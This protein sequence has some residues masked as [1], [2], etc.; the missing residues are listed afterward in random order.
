MS[1]V[2]KQL[3]HVMMPLI[4]FIHVLGYQCNSSSRV[5]LKKMKTME[6]VLTMRHSLLIYIC[7]T[8]LCIR[9]HPFPPFYT[10]LPKI[11]VFWNF[12]KGGVNEYSRTLKKWRPNFNSLHPYAFL[13][14][15]IDNESHHQLSSSL[16]LVRN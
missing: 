15:R 11:I 3:S 9:G 6:V 1:N 16:S 10:I 5:F 2:D 14:I 8:N 4:V 7:G 13:W 12:I